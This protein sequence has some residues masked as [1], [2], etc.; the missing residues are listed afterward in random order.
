MHELS[1]ACDLVDL[2]EA[3]AVSA[4]AERVTVVYLK[5]GIFAGV[6]REALEFGYETAVRGTLLEGSRLEIQ[7]V[8]L[9]IYCPVC[10]RESQA[11]SIQ[12]LHC[13]IC[14]NSLIKIRQGK[15]LEL[16]S[17]EIIEHENTTA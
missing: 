16:M 1:L 13:P 3:A 15:E 9:V 4:G 6:I 2:A 12:L 10:D 8:P 7:E 5:L 14:E 17:M 11:T